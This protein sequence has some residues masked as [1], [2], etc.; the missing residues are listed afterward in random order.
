MIPAQNRG[1]KNLQKRGHNWHY[2]SHGG[3]LKRTF[4]QSL[5]PGPKQLKQLLHWG[6]FLQCMKE[7]PFCSILNSALI[8][9]ASCITWLC[10]PSVAWTCNVPQALLCCFF[11]SKFTDF[12]GISKRPPK[13]SVLAARRT[14]SAWDRKLFH[15]QGNIQSARQ[16]VASMELNGTEHVESCD[17]EVVDASWRHELASLCS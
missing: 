13:T 16:E 9:T 14:E 1:K 8:S 10:A 6:P 12:P 7:S 3:Q 15:M 4:K 11:L 2:V 5:P 17:D